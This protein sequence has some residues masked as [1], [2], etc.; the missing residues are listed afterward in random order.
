M[1]VRR[2]SSSWCERT[3]MTHQRTLR[4]VSNFEQNWRTLRLY[5]YRHVHPPHGSVHSPG[6]GSTEFVRGKRIRTGNGDEWSRGALRLF[7]SRHVDAI[8]LEYHL[9]LL[10]GSVIAVEIKRVRPE[11]PIVMLTDHSELPDGA[12]KSVDAHVTKSDGAH[13][14]W[15]TVHFVLNAKTEQHQEG[16]LT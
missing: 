6:P 2:R 1:W 11:I 3:G 4:L 7:M 12:L 8:V 9:G 16:M 13:F 14:V 5:T 10:D 15:A